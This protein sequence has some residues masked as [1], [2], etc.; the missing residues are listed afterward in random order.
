[1]EGTAEPIGR[2]EAAKRTRQAALTAAAHRLF[3]ERGYEA[4]TVHDIAAAAGL[5]ERTFYRYFDGKEGLLAGE[6]QRWL[7]ALGDAIRGRPSSEQPLTAILNA[8]LAAAGETGQ[9]GMQPVP[10]WLLND[11]PFANLRQLTP[12][13]LLQMETTFAAATLSRLRA[14]AADSPASADRRDPATG[15]RQEFQAEVIARAA[16][17]ALR[18]AVIH[19]RKLRRAGEPGPP[20]IPDLLVQAF[21]IISEQRVQ[22][23]P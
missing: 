13:P 14:T 1:M 23:Q 6:Y 22:H 3:A 16:I 18:S 15:L 2:R 19:H 20:G 7:E 17:S 5:T 11:R 12:R 4:T 10:V 8:V 21:T 9:L